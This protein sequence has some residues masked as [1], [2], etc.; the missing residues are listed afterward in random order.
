IRIVEGLSR[1][2][3]VIAA[4]LLVVAVIIVCEMVVLRYVLEKSTHWQTEFVTYA[5]IASTFI[6]SPYV[7]LTRGHVNVELVPLALGKRGRF[8]LALL[9]YGI[10]A[11]FCFVM[12]GLSFEFW[13]E[14][15]VEEWRSDTIWEP[16]LWQVYLS[17]PVGFFVI[18]LQYLVD[19][20][21]LVTGREP[22]FGMSS[23][24]ETAE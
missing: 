10:S 17:M 4:I 20:L 18:S 12:A 9:A 13:Y 5:L 2:C 11:L 15:W 8:I 7:L 16:L 3:G 6:G 14:A 22:P 24:T 19:L 21:S 1:L 23:A